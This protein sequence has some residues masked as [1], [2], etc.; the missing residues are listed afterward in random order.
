[1]PI[2]TRALTRAAIIAA[3]YT[4]LTLLLAPISFGMAGAVQ[5]RVAEA[6]TVLPILL[7]EAVPALFAGC[8]LSNLLGGAALPDVIFG[9]LAT[10]LAAVLTRLLRKRFWAAASM[11][12]LVNAL[13]VGTLVHMLY[14]PF[15][16]LPL[17]MLYV[18]LGQAVACYG[19]GWLLLQGMKRLPERLLA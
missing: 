1:M 14:T 5:L 10:L 12:V 2:Q 9:S 7:P 3:L 6:L 16:G 18:G 8:L 17:C 13:V 4:A 11:P 19:L 15:I